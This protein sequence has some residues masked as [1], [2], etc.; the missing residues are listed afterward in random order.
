[1]PGEAAGGT[2]VVGDNNFHITT[3]V[4]GRGVRSTRRDLGVWRRHV[5]LDQSEGDDDGTGS[6]PDT[7]AEILVRN[8]RL[9]ELRES[10]L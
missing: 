3:V 6:S 7:V 2:R 5:V 10:H 1:M 9:G 8:R 4:F